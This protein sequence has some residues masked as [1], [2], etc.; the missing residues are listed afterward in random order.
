MTELSNQ[1]AFRWFVTKLRSTILKFETGTGET[2]KVPSRLE[3]R[4]HEWCKENG[5]TPNE[6]DFEGFNDFLDQEE[7][8]V[9]GKLMPKDE[10]EF[11][12]TWIAGKEIPLDNKS[13]R[14]EN[15]IT[16]VDGSKKYT[17]I[18]CGWTSGEDELD[19]DGSLSVFAYYEPTRSHSS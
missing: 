7:A 5:T 4:Y 2:L 19:N 1:N 14:V 3:S 8:N 16:F 17:A 6:E 9:S 18:Q 13:S 10:A 12:V 15:R 11:F